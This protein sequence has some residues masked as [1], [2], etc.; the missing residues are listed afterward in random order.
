MIIEF[1]DKIITYEDEEIDDLQ[2]CYAMTVHKSQDQNFH[3]VLFQCLVF[4]L[5]CLIEIFYTAI[6][7]ASKSVVILGEEWAIKKAIQNQN[8]IKR[9]TFLE[10]LIESNL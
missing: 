5:P 7:R 6:T 2:L 10:N 9:F 4:I 8:A 1:S 3:F